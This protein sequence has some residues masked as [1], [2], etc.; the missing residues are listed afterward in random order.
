MGQHIIN[1]QGGA[2][3]HS[4]RFLP[5]AAHHSSV[6]QTT[7][8]NLCVMTCR[9]HRCRGRLDAKERSTERNQVFMV[10]IFTTYSQKPIFQTTALEIRFKF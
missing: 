7:T 4:P 6:W 2:F 1:Q 9:I 10:T 5:F 3:C 8:K